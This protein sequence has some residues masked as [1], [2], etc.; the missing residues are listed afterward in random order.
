MGKM[1]GREPVLWLALVEIA[2][3]SLCA[4][5]LH[6][7]PDQQS[8]VNA[9]VVAAAGV[10][11]AVSTHDGVSGAI[12]G[13][14]QAVI[15]LGVGFGLHWSADQQAMVMSL[16][17]AVVSAFVRTQVTAPVSSTSMPQPAV[18]AKLG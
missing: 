6:L 17:S 14:V 11:V 5:A 3:K 15:A 8:V 1:L 12:L 2:I 13:L 4:M 7:S 10:L 9:V 16:A 18:A